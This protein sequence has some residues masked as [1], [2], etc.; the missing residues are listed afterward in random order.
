MIFLVV[1]RDLFSA[2]SYKTAVS[3]IS[4]KIMHKFISIEIFCHNTLTNVFE[5]IS[6]NSGEWENWLQPTAKKVTTADF[7]AFLLAASLA[8]QGHSSHK[9]PR[10]LDS[11][12]ETNNFLCF[13]VPSFTLV[14]SLS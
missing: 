7:L 8:S 9:A 1:C 5:I 10:L 3:V 14:K 11:G 12:A 13:P 6:L 2:E 4:Q